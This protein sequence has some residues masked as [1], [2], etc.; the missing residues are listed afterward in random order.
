MNS[1][2]SSSFRC[3]IITPF[4]SHPYHEG[5]F[6]FLANS[7]FHNQWIFAILSNTAPDIF[8]TFSHPR[9]GGCNIH[10]FIKQDFDFYSGELTKTHAMIRIYSEHTFHP[11]IFTSLCSLWILGVENFHSNNFL[12]IASIEMILSQ[13]NSLEHREHF[14]IPTWG[15]KFTIHPLQTF[16]Y[17]SATLHNSSSI[18]SLKIIK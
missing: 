16:L 5:C 13:L 18:F 17:I 6:Q 14:G 2:L 8:F 10:P 4:I 15:L 1:T 9:H 12:A 3:W 11:P 7:S